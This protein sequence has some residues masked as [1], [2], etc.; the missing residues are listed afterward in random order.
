MSN[1]PP[2]TG[3]LPCPAQ[4]C[5]APPPPALQAM[6]LKG[7]DVEAVASAAEVHRETYRQAL[8]AVPQLFLDSYRR[9]GKQLQFVADRRASQRGGGWGCS[10]ILGSGEWRS[11]GACMAWFAAFSAAA[12][13]RKGVTST[14]HGGAEM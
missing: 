12:A 9:R 11:Q 10:C 7:T 4:P 5:P 6:G 13:D 2:P 14:A 1:R 3:N 8:E